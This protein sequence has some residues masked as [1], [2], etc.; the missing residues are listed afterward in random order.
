VL[1]GRM[2]RSNCLHNKQSLH[3]SI[4]DRW[5]E[6]ELAKYG[7]LRSRNGDIRGQLRES[8]RQESSSESGNQIFEL[9]IIK[10]IG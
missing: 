1:D 3:E 7:F 6:D 8:V 5:L 2:G 9:G 4:P 10:N